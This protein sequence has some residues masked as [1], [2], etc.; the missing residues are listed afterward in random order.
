MLIWAVPPLLRNT[1][2]PKFTPS[3]TNWTVPVGPLPEVGVTVAVK[4]TFWPEE[5]G[6]T[7]EVTAVVVSEMLIKV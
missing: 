3:I 6:L 5:E 2:L 4:V 1:K 7:D